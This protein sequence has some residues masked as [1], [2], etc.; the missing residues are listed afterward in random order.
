MRDDAAPASAKQSQFP[1][2]PVS[3]KRKPI[4]AFVLARGGVCYR[5]ELVS[6]PSRC[7]AG[8]VGAPSM[9]LKHAAYDRNIALESR[10][11]RY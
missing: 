11:P 5:K 8:S 4:S 9:P 6:I 2:P 7:F 1:F 10:K 3:D